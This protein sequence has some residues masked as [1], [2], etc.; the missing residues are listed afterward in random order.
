M[1]CK[2]VPLT[3]EHV[4]YLDWPRGAILEDTKKSYLSEGSVA[5]CVLADGVPVFAAGVVNMQWQRGEAW[6]LPTPFFRRN[7]KRCYR[8]VR[9]ILPLASVE[10]NFRRV[11]ATCAVTVSTLLFTHL[12]F[13]Y[14]G[15]M[16]GFGP[17]GETC[18]MYAKVFRP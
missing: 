12:G 6:I 13:D 16:K 9:D 3:R 2:V 8:Y 5:Y 18:H 10:G 4:D 7:I 11:Q 15:T 17:N 1:D 14:E